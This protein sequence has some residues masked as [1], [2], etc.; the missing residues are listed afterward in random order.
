MIKNV[1]WGWFIV[2]SMSSIYNMM[3]HTRYT[4]QINELQKNINQLQTRQNLLIQ[5]KLTNKD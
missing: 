4:S 5:T 2:L 1:L 3:E